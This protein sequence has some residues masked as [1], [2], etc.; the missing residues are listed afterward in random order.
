MITMVRTYVGV[1]E[2]DRDF[3]GDYIGGPYGAHSNVR[4]IDKDD[5]INERTM[6]M[7]NVIAMADRDMWLADITMASSGNGYH[8]TNYA[9]SST[10][11]KQ[12]SN[13][14]CF[15]DIFCYYM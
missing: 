12:S 10:D 1:M 6:T 13:N 5:D 15:A 8:I 9:E 3:T 2:T 7:L 11:I 4:L 14:S